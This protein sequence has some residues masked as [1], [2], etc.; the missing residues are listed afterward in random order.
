MRRVLQGFDRPRPHEAI[1]RDFVWD[2]PSSFNMGTACADWWAEREPERIALRQWVPGGEP[3]ETSYGE[4]AERSSRLAN[5][6][7]SLGCRTG[8]RIAII[9]PQ[10]AETAITHL[11]IYKAGMIAV[12][13]ARLFQPEALEYRLA[14]AG[15][16]VIVTDQAGIGK[17]A[18]IGKDRLS[19][20]KMVI[21]T[22]DGVEEGTWFPVSPFEALLEG[23]PENFPAAETGPDTPALIIFT[24]GTTGPPKGALHGHRVL[25]GHLPGVAT[26]HEFMPQEGDMAWTP[27]DWAWAGGLLNILLPCLYFGVPVVHGGLDRFN[28]EEAFRLIGEMRVRNAFIPPTALRLMRGVEDPSGRYDLALRTIGSGGESLGADTHQWAERKLGVRINEFYG[29]T[30]CNLVLSCFGAAGVMRAGTIG[31]P[32]AGHVVAVI[33]AD[34]NPCEPEVP[35]QIAIRRPDPVMFLGY[36]EDEAA[37]K[38]KFIGDWMNTG[39]QAV[40]DPDGYFHFVGRDD[41]II[42]VAGYRVG[43][44]EIE[45]CLTSHPAV[46][47]AAA[48][49]KP[50]PLK[51]EIVKAYVVLVEGAVPDSLLAEEIRRHVKS[52]LAANIYPKEIEFVEEVP[53]TTTGKVIRR[54]FRE[55]ARSEA[56]HSPGA[57][58]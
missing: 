4:L 13:L 26:H 47:L 11:A 55:R 36:W 25:L 57:A 23:M 37:T 20:L 10:S 1:C 50:D 34:G 35:G 48:V 44:G 3:R 42:N 9:L 41:D 39:D 31:K 54:L 51:G 15:V 53:L 52:R 24:S 29:Q 19:G 30:E 22:D 2:I 7:N 14:R 12:P 43:P 5:A 40:M 27:A 38:A 21:T 49:G 58:L 17:L 46:R 18:A 6:L 28:P 16:S 32:V 45:D 33:D 56:Q 8:D